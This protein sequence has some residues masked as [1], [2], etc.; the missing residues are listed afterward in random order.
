MNT[1]IMA[2]DRLA[3]LATPGDL[4]VD[5]AFVVGALGE[6]AVIML[7]VEWP[8]TATS[9]FPSSSLPLNLLP[10]A[11]FFPANGSLLGTGFVDFLKNHPQ[12]ARKWSPNRPPNRPGSIWGVCASFRFAS[13]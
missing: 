4:V 6:E 13:H 12:M 1:V 10:S 8:R 7:V 2:L 3:A 9:M 5:R 11:P